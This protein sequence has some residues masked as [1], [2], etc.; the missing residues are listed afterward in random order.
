MSLSLSEAA[1]GHNASLIRHLSSLP[2]LADT[3]K[4]CSYESAIKYMPCRCGM[5]TM[6]TY[7]NNEK[8]RGGGL[9][10]YLRTYQIVP[11]RPY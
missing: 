10:E 11:S 5:I 7:I 8:Q 2:P 1:Q 3:F 4:K 6:S 9:C